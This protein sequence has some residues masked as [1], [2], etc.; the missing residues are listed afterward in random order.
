MFFSERF[1]FDI[2]DCLDLLFC[3]HYLDAAF[4]HLFLF[5]Y[6]LPSPD[7]VLFIPVARVTVDID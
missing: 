1:L 3:G 5:N 7:P 2:H 6:S 4:L